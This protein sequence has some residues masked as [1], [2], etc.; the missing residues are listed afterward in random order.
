M[1]GRGAS[2]LSVSLWVP[3]K[4]YRPSVSWSTPVQDIT[5]TIFALSHFVYLLFLSFIL[6]L[7]GESAK[8][9]L[10]WTVESAKLTSQSKKAPSNWREPFCGA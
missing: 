2:N 1:S 5:R 7:V 9:I 6:T 8:V 3:G 4:A 10:T